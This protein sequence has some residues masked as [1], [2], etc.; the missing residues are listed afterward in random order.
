MTENAPRPLPV[1]EILTTLEAGEY[2]RLSRRTLEGMRLD[3]TGP[4]YFKAGPSKRAKV[5][6]RL[7]DLDDWLNQGLV[8]STREHSR[9][10]PPTEKPSKAL[11]GNLPRACLEPNQGL[12]R[13]STIGLMYL[14]FLWYRLPGS[15]GGPQIHNLAIG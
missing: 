15:N 10:H 6:Y 13:G 11:A 7:S 2:L 1:S 3:G 12:L 9:K 14:I 8:R 5:L 4:R